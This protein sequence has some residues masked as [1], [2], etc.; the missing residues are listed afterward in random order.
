MQREF[1]KFPGLRFD[2]FDATR[3][4]AGDPYPAD[5]DRRARRLLFG[6]HL[7]AGEVG[8][9]LS[10]REIWRQCADSSDSA[11]C[12]LED[13]IVL[14]PNFLS[15]VRALMRHPGD[16]DVVR[17]MQLLQRRGSWVA[18]RLEEQTAL[19]AY[20]RQPAG[21]QGYLIQPHAARRLLRHASRIVW[22]IDET[23][24]LYWEH[25]LRLFSVE[26]P[27]IGLAQQFESSIGERSSQRRPQ[28]RKL[29][30]QLINGW[31][32]LRRKLHNLGR[33]GLRRHSA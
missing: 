31:Q 29:Q 25:G 8:C 21:T 26:A 7:R 32:G 30:R 1:A 13:D 23:L 28:W 19:R 20:D 4:N 6:D 14:H 10:H 17:L 15:Q 3:V 11:W 18:Q 16:W 9:F 24:D 33:Y 27:A 2:F 12:V 22:P 5:Y